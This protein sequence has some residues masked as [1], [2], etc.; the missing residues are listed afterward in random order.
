M[1]PYTIEWATL[2]YYFKVVG[3]SCVVAL[4]VSFVWNNIEVK[5]KDGW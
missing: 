4:V 5:D 1:E 2:V 3:L